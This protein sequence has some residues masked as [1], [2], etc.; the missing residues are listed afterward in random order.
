M[1]STVKD[2]SEDA[3]DRKTLVGVL[4]DVENQGMM[5]QA[6]ENNPERK[7]GFLLLCS[8]RYLE[9]LSN[10]RAN[11]LGRYLTVKAV[12]RDYTF[13]K[14]G[15]IGIANNPYFEEFNRGSFS[16]KTKKG[17]IYRFTFDSYV[18]EDGCD[19]YVLSRLLQDSTVKTLVDFTGLA[20]CTASVNN[21]NLV[22]I[23]KNLYSDSNSMFIVDLQKSEVLHT[24]EDKQ[25][26]SDIFKVFLYQPG[27][28]TCRMQRPKGH[29]TKTANLVI[30]DLASFDCKFSKTIPIESD[31]VFFQ[32]CFYWTLIRES[33]QRKSAIL[34]KWNPSTGEEQE[35]VLKS[36]RDLTEE[37][38]I[39][40]ALIEDHLV[41]ISNRR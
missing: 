5:D 27:E 6:S 33:S 10:K 15:E 29:A 30:I 36:K 22:M 16:I 2:T 39:R 21:D 13:F 24:I 41:L 25:E 19:S 31:S 37:S 18:N 7:T 28:L 26:V 3:L 40:L 23:T 35:F 34:A 1:L 38:E 11:N 14:S 17:Y 8:Y 20:G 32:G 12:D 4:V 9:K